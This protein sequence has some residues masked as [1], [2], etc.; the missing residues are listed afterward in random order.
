VPVE[1]AE[2]WAF[3][4]AEAIRSINQHNIGI[5]A[6]YHVELL[7]ASRR[8]FIVG[9]CLTRTRGDPAAC[10]LRTAQESYIMLVT[11]DALSAMRCGNVRWSRQILIS[12]SFEVPLGT[13]RR[14]RRGG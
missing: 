2:R 1:S 11:A 8:S 4:I 13:A 3:R 7:A 10:Q 6:S 5:R 12:R 14:V 9:L